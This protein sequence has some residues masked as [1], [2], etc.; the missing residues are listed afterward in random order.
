MTHDH[1]R[2]YTTL[3]D[4]TPWQSLGTIQAQLMQLVDAN[5]STFADNPPR[6]F[7]VSRRVKKV[8]AGT[9]YAKSDN[10]RIQ[11]RLYHQLLS[12]IYMITGKQVL[13]S[14][15]LHGSC[16]PPVNRVVGHDAIVEV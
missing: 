13:A 8:K 7:P 10:S 4:A 11:V 5:S 2:N 6:P 16:G 15:R 14:F 9:N 1:R 3:T 12:I